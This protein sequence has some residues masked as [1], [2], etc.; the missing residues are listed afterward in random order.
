VKQYILISIIAVL[1]VIFLV[2]SDFGNTTRVYDCGMA[3]WHPDIPLAVKEECRR[4]K[5]IP[6]QEKLITV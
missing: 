3:E 6:T 4:L 5:T 1:L 2:F